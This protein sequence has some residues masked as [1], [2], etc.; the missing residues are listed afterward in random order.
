MS[1]FNCTHLIWQRYYNFRN[2]KYSR[3]ARADVIKSAWSVLR[4]HCSWTSSAPLVFSHGPLGQRGLYGH[5]PP[6]STHCALCPMPG[7]FLWRH[8]PRRPHLSI[9]PVAAC[10]PGPFMGNLPAAVKHCLSYQQL[11]RE[12]LW[13]CGGARPCAGTTSRP[14]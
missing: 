11:P 13:I 8:R 4:L 5:H 9:P 10:S 1:T 12:H 3:Y 6:P 2:F 14:G 7:A